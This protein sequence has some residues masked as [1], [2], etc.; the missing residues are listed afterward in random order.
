MAHRAIPQEGVRIGVAGG[1]DVGSLNI[2]LAIACNWGLWAG[3]KPWGATSA[4]MT[5]MVCGMR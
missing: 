5:D 1:L 2:A 3:Y 4:S